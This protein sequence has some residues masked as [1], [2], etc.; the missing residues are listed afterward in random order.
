M[1]KIKVGIVGGTGFTA[2][3]LIRI[4]LY[5]PDAEISFVTSQSLQGEFISDVHKDLFGKPL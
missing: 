3:E 1:K 4:L 2:G 5:H